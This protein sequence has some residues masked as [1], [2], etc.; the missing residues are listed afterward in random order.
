[1]FDP[2]LLAQ[3]ENAYLSEWG[4]KLR[5]QYNH[6]MYDTGEANT[7]TRTGEAR[8]HKKEVRGHRGRRRGAD[9]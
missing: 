7:G 6:T 9:H 1:M 4:N 2:L 3:G 5:N 8:R